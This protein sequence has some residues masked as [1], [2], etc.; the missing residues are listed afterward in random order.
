MSPQN[1]T[2]FDREAA[3]QDLVSQFEMLANLNGNGPLLDLRKSAIKHFEEL[4][5]PTTRHEE[6]KYSSLLPL[7]KEEFAPAFIKRAH[8]LSLDDLA[9][10]F[11]SECEC[12][13]LVFVNGFYDAALSEIKESDGKISISNLAEGQTQGN[14]LLLKHFSQHA[15]FSNNALSALNTAFA[16][17]GA[18]I[19]VAK[20]AVL[21]YPVH[22]LNITDARTQNTS[23]QNRNLI[24]FDQNS[25]GE[26]ITSTHT[27]GDHKGWSNAITEIVAGQD[28]R[29]KHVLL[30]NDSMNAY[31]TGT[32]QVVQ[33]RN[34]HV[35]NVTIT[36]DGKFIRNDLN[37]L[38]KGEHCESHLF[39]LYHTTEGQHVDN[40]TLVDHA[41]PNCYSNE[42]YKGILDGKSTGVFNGKVMV[43][44]DAQ[45]TNAFQSNKNILLSNHATINTKPQLE[46]FADDVKCS[47]GATTGRLEK[48]ALFYLR[49]RG[50]SEKMAKALLTRAFANEVIDQ[51]RQESLR[52]ELNDKITIKMNQ[53]SE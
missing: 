14:E 11:L 45:K 30:Q 44:Q 25:Q 53:A 31:Y 8:G 27:L 1:N 17:D 20:S 39:G 32:I 33:Y 34:S 41:Q 6:W 15:D 13:R 48:D 50:I 10:Y 23:C 49:V 51:I 29:V 40:H 18:F 2:P 52:A 19:S 22:I 3:Q 4:G 43:R 7:L 5:F 35:S 12:N 37:F 47:H 28:A 36:L 42:L 21:Q 16:T 26:V 46:I 9:P 38:H 24:I